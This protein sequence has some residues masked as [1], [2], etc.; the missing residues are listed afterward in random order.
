MLALRRPLSALILHPANARNHL[1]YA[2][3]EHNQLLQMQPANQ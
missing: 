3:N 1:S 2:E